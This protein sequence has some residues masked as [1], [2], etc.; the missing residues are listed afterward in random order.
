MDYN[1]DEESNGDGNKWVMVMAITVVG[2]KEGSCN[3]SKSDGHSNKG[4][5]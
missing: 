1:V 2:N 3:G 5:G 4:G